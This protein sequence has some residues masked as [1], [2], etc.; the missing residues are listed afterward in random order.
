MAAAAAWAEEVLGSRGVPPTV[1]V[2]DSCERGINDLLAAGYRVVDT[3]SVLVSKGAI[4][5]GHVGESAV[6]PSSSAGPW[7]RTYLDAFYGDRALEASVTPIVR[8]LLRGRV[9]TLLEA[10]IEGRVAGVLA[11]FRTRG[12]A[13][14]YC[15]G[16]VS[17]FRGAGVATGLL[18]KAKEI[19]GVEGR[20]LILQ[21]LASDGAGPF[22]SRRGFSALYTKKMMEKES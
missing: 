18:A 19:A 2:F 21:S 20:H 3:M 4:S 6:R 1:L 8:R 9:A 10:R 5:N 12:V 16:T 15:L 7:V 22:Y 14:V 11:M 13:G 17:E